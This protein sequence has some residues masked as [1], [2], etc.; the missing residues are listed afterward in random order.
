MKYSRQ[1]EVVERELRGRCDH[2]TAVMVYESVR[3]AMP[4]I[5]LGTVYR[6]LKQLVE[7]G[8]AL[9]LE[10]PDGPDRYDG[11]VL[12]HQHV[13]CERCGAVLDVVLGEDFEKMVAREISAKTGAEVRC[14]RLTI[15]GVCRNCGCC[16]EENKGKEE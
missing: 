11:N 15:R 6:D 5:S 3:G 7:E 2:P 4:E 16:A 12:A 14:C 13:V 9:R 10:M 1:R 8:Q